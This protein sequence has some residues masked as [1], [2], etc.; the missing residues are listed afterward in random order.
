MMQTF[1]GTFLQVIVDIAALGLL[2]GPI[3]EDALNTADLTPTK[4]FCCPAKEAKEWTNC[5]W[6]L[7]QPGSCFDNHCDQG[8]QVQL[9][10]SE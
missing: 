9:A 4:R 2:F 1:A 8:H 10:Q 5:K 3:L 7:G 6:Q